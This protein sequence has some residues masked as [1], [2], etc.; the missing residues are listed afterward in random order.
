MIYKKN[1]IPYIITNETK[2]PN[3][4]TEIQKI[5]N[6]DS[7]KQKQLYVE[8]V[9]NLGHSINLQYCENYAEYYNQLYEEYTPPDESFNDIISSEKKNKEKKDKYKIKK[10]S[11]MI[12]PKIV[13]AFG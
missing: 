3:I 1:Y 4:T 10:S 13:E 8:N 12:K 11:P 7:K 2:K 6:N 5:K 9:N